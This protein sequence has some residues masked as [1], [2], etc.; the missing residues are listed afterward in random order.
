MNHNELLFTIS[1]LVINIHNNI[2]RPTS[3]ISTLKPLVDG[4]S[5]LPDFAEQETP[6]ECAIIIHWTLNKSGIRFI[7]I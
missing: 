1:M 7:E 3:I 2:I 5:H 6:V 4:V